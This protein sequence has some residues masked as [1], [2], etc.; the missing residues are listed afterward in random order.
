M[1]G[2][3]ALRVL[4]SGPAY[5]DRPGAIGSCYLV[6]A[7]GHALVL[8]LG[9]G[10]YSALAA[11]WDPGALE[12]VV[13]SHLHPDHYIDLVALRHHL[14]WG[15]EPPRRARVLGP[16]DLA[17]RLDLLHATPGFSAASLDVEPLAEGVRQVG[18]FGLETR[19]VMHTDESYAFRVNPGDARGG[20][21]GRAL[22]YSGDC[23]RADDLLPLVRPGDLLL[24]EAS[25][26]PGPGDPG[27]AHLDA[28][29]VGRVA[30]AAG[31]SEVLLTHLLDWRRADETIDACRREFDGPVRLVWPG[32]VLT[33]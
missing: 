22:V 5:S 32:D 16:A 27:A 29:A 30:A 6:E 11:A 7:D 13:I 23:G 8:D 12:A 4:G 24:A 28:P 10:A 2:R 18:P 15:V 14:R 33:V 31:A 26:G 9:H 21:P 19:R 1:N 17:D 20:A 25:W 3:M